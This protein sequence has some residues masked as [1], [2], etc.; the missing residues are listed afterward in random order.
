MTPSSVP[1]P[2]RLA[3]EAWPFT[4]SSSI[5]RSTS[6]SASTSA[7]L[8]SIIA[9]PVR[10]RSAFTSAAETCAITNPLS[11]CRPW[12]RRTKR[13]LSAA[14]PP[15]RP[16]LPRL[17]EARARP[18][19]HQPQLSRQP[20]RPEP[21]LYRQP[22]ATPRRRRF[23]RSNRRV[24]RVVPSPPQ[25][26]RRRRYHRRQ[27]PPAELLWAPRE[28]L[29]RRPP[30]QLSVSPPRLSPPPVWR[31]LPRL[32]WPAA[33]GGE[34][35]LPPRVCA[36]LPPRVCGAPSLRRSAFPPA[37]A[38]PRSPPRPRRRSCR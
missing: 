32:L 31:L 12:P 3:A 18:G 7:A 8:L 23:P 24:T 29:S 11:R 16:G 33:P 13:R 26:A 17:W 4:R 14:L 19:Q 37:R 35:S 36:A 1:R 5:A 25:P 6:P 9:A 2:S 30:R 38:R 22:E 10:S 21:A 20:E 28:R 34:L 15:E 27:D